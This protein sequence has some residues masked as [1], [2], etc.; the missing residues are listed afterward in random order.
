HDCR[1]GNESVRTLSAFR[2]ILLGIPE[3]ATEQQ[4]ATAVFTIPE[5]GSILSQVTGMW[6]PNGLLAMR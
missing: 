2:L 6:R 3:S 5:D 1:T 4:S